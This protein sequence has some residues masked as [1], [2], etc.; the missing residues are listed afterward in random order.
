M[1]RSPAKRRCS[2]LGGRMGLVREKRMSSRP[3][4][5]VVIVAAGLAA[6]TRP[7]PPAPA[8]GRVDTAAHRA[9]RRRAGQLALARPHVQRAALQSA[10]ARSRPK[11]SVARS[12]LVVRLE[13]NRGA[14]AT[15]IVVDGV[16]YV[17]SAWSIV[18]ALDARTGQTLWVYDPKVESRGRRQGV[19]RRRQ[20]RRGRPRRQGVRRRDRRPTARARRGTGRSPGRR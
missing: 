15:P 13:M 3:V 16:M 9:R 7:M 14:E 10:E 18:H 5:A 17:T 19:L 12:G 4:V 20:S 2:R 11:R 8:A 1:A 6:C